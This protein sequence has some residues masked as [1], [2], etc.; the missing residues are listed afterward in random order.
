MIVKLLE[1]VELKEVQKPD[2]RKN[3]GLKKKEFQL[4]PENKKWWLNKERISIKGRE[5]KNVEFKR[6]TIETRKLK[7]DEL[8]SN[9]NKKIKTKTFD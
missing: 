5:T 8:R 7:N 1:I 3:V 9:C 6:I 2:N 4:N